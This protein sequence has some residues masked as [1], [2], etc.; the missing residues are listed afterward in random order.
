MSQSKAPASSAHQQMM[1][2]QKQQQQQQ[3]QYNNRAG[4]S[5]G[6]SFPNTP[7]HNGLNSSLMAN[8]NWMCSL[9]P[10]VQPL[11]R[12]DFGGSPVQ[13]NTFQVVPGFAQHMQAQF[14]CQQ[15]PG[16]QCGCVPQ[17]ATF[18]AP[19]EQILG[20]KPPYSFPCLIGLALRSCES[21]RMSVSQIYDHVTGKF[22]YFRTAKAGWKNSVRH[23]LSL[24]KI[25]C[26]LE[27]LPTEAGKGAMWGIAPGMKE[28]LERDI[29]Q[30]EQR[31]PQKIAEAMKEPERPVAGEQAQPQQGQPMQLQMMG[32]NAQ[33]QIIFGTAPAPAPA[34]SVPPTLGDMGRASSAPTMP[35]VMMAQ[36]GQYGNGMNFASPPKAMFN[37]TPTASQKDFGARSA[38]QVQE[39]PDNHNAG[40][41]APS[42]RL[43]LPEGIEQWNMDPND[44]TIND[45]I[46]PG[47]LDTQMA[48]PTKILGGYD[49]HDHMGNDFYL[50]G[51]LSPDGTDGF[52][53]N[54]LGAYD[55]DNMKMAL[56]GLCGRPFSPP[57]H[58]KME[59][60]D[61]LQN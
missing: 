56:G 51:T 48:S 42:R 17:V 45:L 16:Q 52:S 38:Q 3:A 32:T 4:N 21:G 20:K 15:H 23:N 35:M 53:L 49:D 27:R 13:F 1:P 25:F 61:S 57:Q 12:G 36:P 37:T 10:G 41:M 40:V 31:H 24:N 19:Q 29:S 7:A 2:S 14:V 28:Q 39:T 18:A 30:C 8:A 60:D 50:R 22:P 47:T 34:R 54:S 6:S 5:N 33:G 26:K 43:S 46:Q 11:F 55:D 44:F 59:M 9:S 58:I